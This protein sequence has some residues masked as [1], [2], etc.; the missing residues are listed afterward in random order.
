MSADASQ[1]SASKLLINE[2]NVR[3]RRILIREQELVNRLEYVLKSRGE[4]L[5]SRTWGEIS[6]FEGTVWDE[7]DW[8][9]I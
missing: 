5:F 6:E 4:M 7:N 3:V 2:F 1:F 8:K 9:C